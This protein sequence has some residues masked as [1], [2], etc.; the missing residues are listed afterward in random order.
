LRHAEVSGELFQSHYGMTQNGRSN[1]RFDFSPP[2]VHSAAPSRRGYVSHA[3][4]ACE[5]PLLDVGPTAA[6]NVTEA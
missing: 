1:L 3:S 2:T 5:R 4:K 6:R